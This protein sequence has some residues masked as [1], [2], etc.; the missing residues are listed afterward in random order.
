L[1]NPPVRHCASQSW[2][3][4]TRQLDWTFLQN[5]TNVTVYHFQSQLVWQS[6]PRQ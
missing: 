1:C 2:C 3:Q 4:R 5:L 6:R